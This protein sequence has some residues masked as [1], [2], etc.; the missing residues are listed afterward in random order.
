MKKTVILV[1]TGPTAVGKSELVSRLARKYPIE[2]LNADSRQVYRYMPIGTSQPTQEERLKSK[3]HLIDFLE[4][5][6][7][8][9]AGIFISYCKEELPKIISHNKIPVIVGGSFFY[10]KSLWMDYWKNP[11]FPKSYKKK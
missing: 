5:D 9:S 2:V 3:Y 10:I 11:T 7:A 4:P 1:I 8:F 6:K